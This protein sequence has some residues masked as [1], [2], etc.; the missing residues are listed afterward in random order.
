MTYLFI[1]RVG[2]RGFEGPIRRW[3][4]VACGYQ[5]LMHAWE[6]ACSAVLEWGNLRREEYVH[7]YEQKML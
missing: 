4:T 1:E 2:C 6:T 7:C 3:Y 5:G